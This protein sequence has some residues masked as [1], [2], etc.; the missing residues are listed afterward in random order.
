MDPGTVYSLARGE[1]QYGPFTLEQ[2]RHQYVQGSLQPTDL[3]WCPGM[4]TWSPNYWITPQAI[5]PPDSP[6]GSVL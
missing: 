3:V 1:H 2:L 6:A 4:T 5:R